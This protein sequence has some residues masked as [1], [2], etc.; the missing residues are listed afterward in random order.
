MLLF[1]LE[2]NQDFEYLNTRLLVS[3]P[4]S[5]S[6]QGG[7]FLLDFKN[8]ALEKLDTGSCSG[9][10]LVK[11]RSEFFVGRGEL[12]WKKTTLI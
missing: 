3:F 10:T 2:N 9:M 1:G 7:L 12:K 11:N 6:D 4:A 5:G 8:N